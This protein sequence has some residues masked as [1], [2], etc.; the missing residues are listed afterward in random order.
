MWADEYFTRDNGRQPVK[1]WLGSL[2]KTEEAVV[3]SKMQ[4][5]RERG[6]DL[7]KIQKLKPIKNRTAKEKRDKCLYELICDNYRI[8]TY[9]DTTRNIF[10]YLSVWKKQ[11]N[12]QPHDIEMCRKRLNEYL[13]QRGER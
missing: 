12:K 5:L 10:I 9:Y 13:V 11:R 2:P 3:E 8:G 1:R 7:I 6:F 4:T